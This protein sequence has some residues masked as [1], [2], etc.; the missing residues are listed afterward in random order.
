MDY[1]GL[2]IREWICPIC[3]SKH[4]RDVNAAINIKN[5]GL[6]ILDNGTVRNTE[7]EETL[8]PSMPVENPTMDE[9]LLDIKSSDSTK[10]ELLYKDA[11]PNRE[12]PVI[13]DSD[14]FHRV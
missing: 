8:V 9:R 13:Y 4:D 12:G 6:R 3:H 5:E 2:E 10:Q 14:R 11:T 7:T 1:M